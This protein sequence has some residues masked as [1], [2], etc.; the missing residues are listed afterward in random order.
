MALSE[1]K[2]RKVATRY[3]G[4]RAT[5]EEIEEIKELANKRNKTMSD[6]IRELINRELKEEKA[7]K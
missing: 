5:I 7:N 1:R 2:E 4:F 6:L 3:A